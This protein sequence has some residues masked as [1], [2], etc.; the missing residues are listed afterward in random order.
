MFLH[1]KFLFEGKICFDHL[2]TISCSQISILLLSLLQTRFRNKATSGIL[3]YSQL[4]IKKTGNKPC[5]IKLFRF[6]CSEND[7][8]KGY[9]AMN[10][11]TE[12]QATKSLIKIRSKIKFV[13][14]HLLDD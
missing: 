10:L 4:L 7:N 8:E 11:A 3:N 12:S 5:F 6:Q 9:S 14:L 1:C 13:A 2:P